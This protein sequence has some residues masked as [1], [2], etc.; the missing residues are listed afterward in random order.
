MLGTG[1]KWRMGPNGVGPVWG[2]LFWK[3]LEPPW[4]TLVP[5]IFL[6]PAGVGFFEG[7]L[8]IIIIVLENSFGMPRFDLSN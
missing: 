8:I 6:S 7:D 3:L 5:G 4:L 2:F 1:F